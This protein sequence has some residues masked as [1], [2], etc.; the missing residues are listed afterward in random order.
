MKKFIIVGNL[1]ACGYKEV[2]TYI[3]NNEVWLGNTTL[4]DFTCYNSDEISTVACR[5]LTNVD[6]KKRHIP[7]DLYKRYSNEY[8]HY[9][10]YDAIDC[11]KITDIPYDYIGK[12][13]VPISFLDSYCPQQFR[14]LGT[15]TS[16][17]MLREIGV[18]ELGEEGIRI[19]NDC[20]DKTNLSPGHCQLFWV[21]KNKKFCRPFVRL[22]VEK[23]Y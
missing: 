6:H 8:N 18:R 11:P 1:N 7:I 16:S 22:V 14:L 23:L 19:K 9:Y 20:G 21:D 10:N 13:G 3:K 12:I 15:S 17:A 4:K 5:W 2:F